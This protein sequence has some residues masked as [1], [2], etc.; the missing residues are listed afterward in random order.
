MPRPPLRPRRQAA[1]SGNPAGNLHPPC[2]SASTGGARRTRV[3]LE[4]T[5]ASRL[6]DTMRL[7]H[8]S[9]WHLGQTF[10]N[11]DRDRE[12]ELFLGWL[13]D[14]LAAERADALLVA[15]DIFDNANPSAKSQEQLYRFLSEAKRRLPDLGI[16]LIAGNHDSPARLEAPSPLLDAFGVRVVGPARDGGG[17]FDPERL[18]VPLARGGGGI[19]AWCL[20]VPFL[21]PADLAASENND[22]LELAEDD[23]VR[24]V[25]RLYRRVLEAALARRE[26][27]QALIALGHCHLAGGAVSEDSER[28]IVIGGSEALPAGVFDPELAYVALG[29][30]HRAQCIGGDERLR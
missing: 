1:P 25:R 14:T 13:L 27:G 10:H 8:T 4:S 15:G 28:R 3:S 11:F 30:L 17:E 9:D 7:L 26:P 24:G 12:H 6:G 22:A 19:A 18:L 29:H 2:F 16:V 23:Y 5:P 21:R 20:A